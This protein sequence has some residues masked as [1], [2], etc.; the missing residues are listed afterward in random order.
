MSGRA[1]NG[2]SLRNQ[3]CRLS[4]MR[5]PGPTT[6]GAVGQQGVG[7]NCGTV[8]RRE[9]KRKKENVFGGTEAFL[10]FEHKVL[11]L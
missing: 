6:F 5:F 9:R 4:R 7:D 3:T 10:T 8:S 1:F 2:K 11:I